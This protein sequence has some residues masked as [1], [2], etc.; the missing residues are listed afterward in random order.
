[1]KFPSNEDTKNITEGM[2]DFGRYG[3]FQIVWVRLMEN[4]GCLHYNYKQF[5]SIVLQGVVGPDYRFI[6]I[7]EGVYGKE[8]KRVMAEYFRIQIC[9]ECYK[10]VLL[11]IIN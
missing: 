7:E 5:F 3:S 11:I 8:L 4:T 10:T 6:A 1:M 2:K 9:Q